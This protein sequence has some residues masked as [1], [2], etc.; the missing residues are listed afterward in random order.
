MNKR[1]ALSIE[2][3]IIIILALL[4]LV[5]I[6]TAFSGGMKELWGRIM[7]IGATATEVEL[8]DAQAS[9]A[10]LCGLPAYDT[11]SFFVKGVGAK[12]CR[13]IKPC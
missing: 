5:I 8:S 3:I 11:T 7:G 13:E 9:C 2:T 1:G 4:V 12:T 6:A 10:K